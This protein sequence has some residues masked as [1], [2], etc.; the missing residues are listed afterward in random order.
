MDSLISMKESVDLI[1]NPNKYYS[2]I[3]EIV[4]VIIAV[5]L[6]CSQNPNTSPALVNAINN[7]LNLHFKEIDEII[8]KNDENDNSPEMIEDADRLVA[9]TARLY[10]LISAEMPEGTTNNALFNGLVSKA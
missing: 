5:A 6:G 1:S 10:Q 9:L 3:K 2:Q 8:K 4:T 7:E